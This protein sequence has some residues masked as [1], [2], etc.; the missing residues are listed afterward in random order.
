MKIKTVCKTDEDGIFPVYA[1]YKNQTES[2]SAFVELD[3]K[4]KLLSAD[5]SSNI[6]STIPMYVYH[7]HA[8]RFPILSQTTKDTINDLL[9]E[10]EPLANRVLGGYES[11]WN[12]NNYVGKF[13]DDAAD[14]IEIIERICEDI[15]SRDVYERC[16]V[17]DWYQWVEDDIKIKIKTAETAE[18]IAKEL[19]DELQDDLAG[20]IAINNV[21]P[22]FDQS[23][24]ENYLEHRFR[25]EF[26]DIEEID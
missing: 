9:D 1:K 22:D 17:Y 25:K 26:E 21:V 8:I 2:Q 12:G 20:D 13:T 24:I 4:N 11:V 23:D 19:W 5:Y 6:G 18:E 14:A 3:L 15:P 7:R 10:I 16:D